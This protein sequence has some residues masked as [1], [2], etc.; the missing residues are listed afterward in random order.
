MSRRLSP[1]GVTLADQVLSSVSNVLAVVLVARVLDA[2]EFGRF[3][4]GYGVLTLVLT[5]SRQYFGTRVSLVA[6]HEQARELT[7]ALVTACVLIA[8]LVALLVFAVSFAATGGGSWAILVVVALATPLVCMQDVIRFGAVAGGR[9]W[10]ACAS[11]ALWVAV[12]AVPFVLGATLTPLSALLLWAAGALAA[13]LLGALMAGTRLRLP[14]GWAELRTRH[15]VGDSLTIGTL[16]TQVASFWVLLVVSRAIG[17]PAAGSLRGAGTC[18]GPV[19]V[20]LAFSGLGLT[21]MLV[22]RAREADLR[23]CVITGTAFGAATALWG[24]L[25]LAVPSSVG[26]AGFGESWEGI[27][28]VLPWTTLEYVALSLASAA[29]LG[30]KVR[31]R[32]RPLLHQRIAVSAVTAVGGTVVAIVAGE[33]WL[34][35][36][37][38]AASAAVSAV[39]GWVQLAASRPPDGRSPRRRLLSAR[40]L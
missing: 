26:R 36:A 16:L 17:S 32:A 4:V 30:L 12:M 11:D 29:I 27:R 14:A 37:A 38:L 1:R 18:M 24:A 3:A 40:G 25:L 15:P 13:L 39:Y 6:A 35:A 8:P 7:A 5:L 2:A 20:L 31:G 21:P 9:P 10:A 23:F 19:N 28:T 34:V 22:A 33:V